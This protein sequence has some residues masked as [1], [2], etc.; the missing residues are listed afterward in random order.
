MKRIIIVRIL[1]SALRPTLMEAKRDSDVFHSYFL[2]ELI[3]A[4]W[5]DYIYLLSLFDFNELVWQ[6]C[7]HASRMAQDI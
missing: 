5:L 2:L 7:S 3:I 4:Q 1:Q 6:E